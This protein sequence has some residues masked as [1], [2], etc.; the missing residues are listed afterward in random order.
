M[1]P[2]K[3]NEMTGPSVN[4]PAGKRYYKLLAERNELVAALRDLR[5]AFR[6]AGHLHQQVPAAINAS[7]L[8]A[9]L[10]EDK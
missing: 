4:T 6:A 9:R 3:G 1:V 2:R 10:G 7:A 8:L 5:V